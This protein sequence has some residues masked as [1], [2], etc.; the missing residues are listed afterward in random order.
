M[1]LREV[2]E[3]IETFPPEAT[4]FA[5]GPVDLGTTVMV[6]EA[7][8][9]DDLPDEIDGMRLVMDI[10]HVSD[11]LDGLRQLLR[12]QNGTDPSPDQLFERF[13]VYL[14]NDA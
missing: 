5:V 9:D 12:G 10:W 11:T 14:K 3:Q 8:S 4:V 2:L 6:L 7:P 13:L 1:T